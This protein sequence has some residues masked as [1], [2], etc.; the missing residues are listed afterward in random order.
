MVMALPPA[1]QPFEDMLIG[2]VKDNPDPWITKLTC[3]GAKPE[4]HL[5]KKVL[6]FD[7]VLLL[8][9]ETR[10]LTLTNKSL[11][12]LQYRM[13]DT[14]QLGDGFAFK[15][16]EGTLA[17]LSV[18][19]IEVEFSPVRP[20]LYHNKKIK[21]EITEHVEERAVEAASGGTARSGS[22]NS[23]SPRSPRA[24]LGVLQSETI[25]V[26]AE[27]FDV[28]VDLMFPKGLATGVDFGTIKV[29][30][31]SK[32]SFTIK[33]KGKY[34]IL[35]KAWLED[36]D[37]PQKGVKPI[38]HG[39]HINP[40]RGILHPH[41][42]PLA[43]QMGFT[44]ET[45]MWIKAKQML[46]VQIFDFHRK[47]EGELIALIPVSVSV[48]ALFCKYSVTPSEELH[49]GYFP[50]AVRK[51]GFFVI[52]NDGKFDFNYHIIR[53]NVEPSEQPKEKS[54]KS[55]APGAKAGSSSSKS[56]SQ[57]ASGA[58]SV[59]SVAQTERKPAARQAS[60]ATQDAK[61]MKL[62]AGIFSLQP[63]MGTIA[64]GSQA[65]V[66]V[67]A[68]SNE[69]LAD[70]QELVIRISDAGDGV[71]IPFRL[72]AVVT[73]ASIRDRDGGFVG[74]FEE[75]CVVDSLRDYQP[76]SRR[77]AAPPAGV[78]G[79]EENR[80]LLAPTIVGDA[81]QRRRSTCATPVWCL[82]TWSS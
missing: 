78:Y 56:T 31:E 32:Q 42:R 43:I 14:D 11:I 66:N 50:V 17:P 72:L 76:G 47:E 77:R 70:T 35:F 79:R 57:E 41:E 7:R 25:T 65:V 4:V 74:I 54:R 30:E 71:G 8:R 13:A 75:Y 80:F 52:K 61:A 81:C 53:K 24:T 19:E 48:R 10:K 68:I 26:S 49:M 55:R 34:E 16:R 63:A 60:K 6:T 2:C 64:V 45:E 5:D 9:Q 38:T 23:V 51:L 46:R 12:P 62:A 15:P 21:L 40:D 29:K 18:S 33:N 44:T 20:C 27:G 73:T 82:W 67:E 58:M 28:A 39:F 69:S 1:P 59:A 22:E 3:V 37:P 36:P